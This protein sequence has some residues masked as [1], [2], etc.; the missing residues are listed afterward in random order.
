MGEAALINGTPEWHADRRLGIG[1]SDCAA[2]LG[3]SRWKTPFQLYLE[4]IGEAQPEDE[5]WEMERG[6]AM[7]PLLRQ[8]FADTTKL[9]V[10]LPNAAIVHPLYPWM[11]YNPDGLCPRRVLGEF[12][13]ASSYEGWGEEGTDEIPIEYLLQVQHG[14]ACLDYEVAKCSVSINGRKPRY[15]E[16]PA[17]KELQEMI[18]DG[19]NEFWQAVVDRVPP[20]PRNAE[21]CA[22]MFRAVNGASVIINEPTRFALVELK[23]VKEKIKSLEEK[24]E[25]FEVAL[26]S[27]MGNSEI[28]VDDR[29]TILATWKE[30]NGKTT[31]DGASLKRDHPDIYDKYSSKGENFRR[32]LVK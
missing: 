23:D 32:L 20:P 8:H 28:L 10:S 17:D 15:Y 3:E 21:D 6:K 13:T 26:K 24:K 19:E 2:A 30:Q 22:A 29:R 7:E 18:I 9:E 14:L 31:I 5:T 16:I 4:K 27:C 11:R 1:G 12:K 25:L